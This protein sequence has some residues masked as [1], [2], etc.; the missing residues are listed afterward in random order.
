MIRR[1]ARKSYSD[2]TGSGA[3][4]LTRKVIQIMLSKSHQPYCNHLAETELLDRSEIKRVCFPHPIGCEFLTSHLKLLV[5][6]VRR[7]S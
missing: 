4:N 3:I 2:D 1:A 7:S 5:L 6:L